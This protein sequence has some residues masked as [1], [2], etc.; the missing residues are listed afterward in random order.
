MPRKRNPYGMSVFKRKGRDCYEM[1]WVDPTTGR[2]RTRSTGQAKKK[3]ADRWAGKRIEELV[4]ETSRT[5]DVT[6]DEFCDRYQTE[7]ASALSDQAQR[8]VIT[9]INSI[10]RVISPKLLRA[11]DEKQISIFQRTLRSEGLAESTIKGYLAYLS[12]ALHWA[13]R[14]K[15][16]DAV[17][18][19]ELPKRTAR[20]KGRPVTLEEF[21][22]MLA[23]V[24]VV[25]CPKPETVTGSAPFRNV[26]DDVRRQIAESWKH[27]LRGLWWSGLRLAEALSLHWTDNRKLCVDLSGPVLRF[28][29]DSHKANRYDESP[30]VPE[31]EDFLRETPEADRVGYV[32]NPL[33]QTG[34]RALRRMDCVSSTIVAIGTAAGVKVNEKPRLR[35][36]EGQPETQVKYASAHDLRRSFGFRWARR[37]MPALLMQFMR[38][39]SI[40]TTMQFYATRNASAAAQEARAALEAEQGRHANAA[41]NNPPLDVPFP[42]E[43]A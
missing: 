30:L 34:Q 32:F 15:L 10:N 12:A 25:V 39:A 40:N 7:V 16:I 28:Q 2:K 19:I 38:H 5:A 23:K 20:A 31:F 29:P 6:W 36:K 33:A 21:E 17:P 37:V 22:R 13:K 14:Q 18:S 3:D 26:P 42:C 41:A 8:K 1:Q 27:L 9:M 4:A 11:L 43:N 24:E 35:K